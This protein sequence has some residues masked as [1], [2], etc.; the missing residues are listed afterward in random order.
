[1]T[2]SFRGWFNE[3]EIK[4]L[5]DGNLVLF[6]NKDN[7]YF[8]CPEES[9]LVFAKIKTPDEDDE[10]SFADEAAFLAINLSKAMN[11]AEDEMP[12]RLFYKKDLNNIKLMDKDELEKILF[13]KG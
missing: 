2:K 10:P 1:M 6:F 7:E 11:D 13:K 8:G 12:K 5:L 4:H 9:R 3:R